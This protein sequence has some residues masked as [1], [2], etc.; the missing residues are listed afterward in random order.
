MSKKDSNN[1]IQRRS[2]V[3]AMGTAA[4]AGMAVSASTANAQ[5]SGNSGFTPMRHTNDAW[6]D[7]LSGSHRVFIDSS[8][9][10]GGSDGLI[11]AGN[12]LN[13]HSQAYAGSDADYAMVLC[14]RHFSTPFAFSDAVWEKYGEIFHIIMQFP[15]PATGQAPKI[16]LM[17]SQAARPVPGA[18]INDLVSRNLQFAVC[19]MAA[20]FFSGLIA[21]NM[22][23]SANAVFEELKDSVIP[24]SR[25]VSAGVIAT[26][27]A[28]EY[29]YSLLYAG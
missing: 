20:Q 4:L 5:N 26:T 11:Y 29:G 25:F 12:I 1:S 14:F 7:D 16:N 9:A 19:E 15:D 23:L 17:N 28:Q 6:L 3:K 13:A 27:R 8:T 24:N 22:G 21:N 2:M 10:A 18:T